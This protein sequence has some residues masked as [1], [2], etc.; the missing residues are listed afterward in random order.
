MSDCILAIDQG[1]TNSKALALDVAGR[2]VASG[3][4]AV[5]I[6]FPRPGW[7]EHD[8]EALLGRTL[9]AVGDCLQAAGGDIRILAAGITNQRESVVLWERASGRP[10]GPCISWQCRRTSDQCEA[11]RR[12]GKGTWIEGKTGLPLDPLFSATK[13]SWLLDSVPDGRRRAQAGELCLGTVDSW[14]LFRFTGG[15][16]HAT[17]LSNASRTQLVDLGQGTWDDALLELFGVP[18]AALP[19]IR[20]SSGVFGL[21]SCAGLPA[22]VPIAGM[23]GDSHAAMFG[24]AAFS[25][26]VVKATY[27]TGSSLM[28]LSGVPAASGHG[29]A[30]TVAWRL[31]GVAEWA[32]EGNIA[33]SGATLDWVGRLLGRDDPVAAVMVLAGEVADAGGVYLVP[34]FAGLGAPY[35]DDSARGL[36]CG[37]TRGTS[38]AHLARAALESVAYQVRDVF[39]AMERAAGMP[40]GELLV[41]GGASRSD[42]LMQF[43][44]DILGRP[45][46][47]HD[48]L[49]LSAIG[50]A[51][52]AGLAMGAWPGREALSALERDAR[53][54][55]PSMP[56]GRRDAL[57]GSWQGAVARARLAPMENGAGRA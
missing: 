9:K 47:R 39:D 19:E 1:T 21:A 57:Y 31:Q 4:C 46:I 53:R 28:T 10:L 17:D 14:L 18:R 26:G 22:G 36:V 16:V 30:R 56:A 55:V 11:L 49:H 3:S 32:L 27:G 51:W 37:L 54:F 8:P 35:W 13:M 50:V 6:H 23:A 7:C 24:Q 15:R 5:P 34:A 40:L 41:D 42:A 33:M 25:P 38:P 29:L 43:Q 45:V 48:S 20:D 12:Q 44:A 2:V 52:L